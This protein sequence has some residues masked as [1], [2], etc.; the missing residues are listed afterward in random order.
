MSARILVVEDDTLIREVIST[1]LGDEGYAVDVA[2]DGAV[3][4]DYLA[5]KTPDL[6]VLDLALPAMDGFQV[7]QAIRRQESTAE[8]PVLVV[9]AMAS[10]NIV[11]AAYRAGADAY[12]DKP[13][14]LTDFLR[15]VQSLL[16]S[17]HESRQ[18]STA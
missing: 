3:A 1:A 4:V 14:D 6:V 16:D 5:T 8:I 13:F 7:C 12:I 11:K 10:T 17:R 2:E 9:S 18:A 15:N